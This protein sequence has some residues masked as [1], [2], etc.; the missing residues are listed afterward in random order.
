MSHDPRR[1]SCFLIAFALLTGSV[2]TA[3]ELRTTSGERTI[4]RTAELSPTP[5]VGPELLA[6]GG[7]VD[8]AVT[9]DACGACGVSGCDM[10]CLSLRNWHAKAEYLL[11]WRRG[12]DMPPLVT[13]DPNGGVLP[14]ATV[15]FGGESLAG[16]ASPGGRLT[17]GK[18][19]D[20]C[21]TWAAEGR[22]W[23]LSENRIDF[24]SD[25][26]LTVLALPYVLQPGDVN[27]VTLI[28]SPNFTGDGPAGPANVSISGQ[29]QVLGGDALLRWLGME[30]ETT[31]FDVMS[32]YQFARLD[33]DLGINAFTTL[34]PLSASPGTTIELAESFHTRNEFHAGA[35]GIAANYVNCQW[36]V[37]LLAKIAFGHM[38]QSAAIAGQRTTT[39]TTPTTVVTFGQHAPAR[40]GDRFVRRTFAFSPEVGINFRYSVNECLALTAGY[41]YIYWNDVLQAG[42]QIDVRFD[43][44]PDATSQFPQFAF[45]SGSYWVHG[46]NIGVQGRF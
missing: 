19:L 32:G 27:M 29:S 34:G 8:S 18:W 15:L 42:S 30:T 12:Q 9:V 20:E 26:N 5:D 28:K 37:D 46:V 41:S 44:L 38:R 23:M 14:G 24:A 7:G 6:Y 40:N 17:L 43:D 45:N 25:P 11:W 33:E 31:R 21:Q 13:T 2:V 4:F 39:D 35:I 1:T 3:A 10:A 16:D 36:Q 22:F